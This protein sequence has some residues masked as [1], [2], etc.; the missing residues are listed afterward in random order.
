MRRLNQKLA[1]MVGDIIT[2]TSMQA[3]ALLRLLQLS[4]PAL[5]IG[6]F[7]YSQGLESAVSQ[8]WL[9]NQSEVEQWL[10]GL[11]QHPLRYLDTPVLQRLYNA[12]QQQNHGQVNYWND[13]LFASRETRELQQED[14]HLGAALLRL[15]AQL[16]VDFAGQW[17]QPERCCFATAFSLAAVHWQLAATDAA[18]GYLWAWAENQVIAAVKL[19]PLVQTQGQQILSALIPVIIDTVAVSSTVEDAGIG[20]TTPGLVMASVRHETQYS[21]L[22]RS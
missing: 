18:Y 9:Q 14:G 19:V 22:F 15:L 6:A 12:W 3:T 5:P 20:C 11:L 2:I 16:Q 7:A 4:S 10:R 8:G 21:R 1:H 17:Q 13:Y